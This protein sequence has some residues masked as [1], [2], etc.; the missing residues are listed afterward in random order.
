LVDHGDSTNEC[1]AKYDFKS[2]GLGY[3]NINK[4]NNS[5]QMTFLLHPK[6]YKPKGTP[7]ANSKG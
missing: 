6:T 2:T 7:Y 3:V 1:F 5:G 4:S